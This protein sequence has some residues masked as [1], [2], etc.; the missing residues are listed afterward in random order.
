MPSEQESWKPVDAS[1]PELEKK[2]EALSTK[3]PQEDRVPTLSTKPKEEEPER[4]P[5]VSTSSAFEADFSEPGEVIIKQPLLGENVTEAEAS[6]SEFSTPLAKSPLAS[7]APSTPK[8]PPPG[9]EGELAKLRP[10]L[11]G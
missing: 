4:A 2:M 8:A 9:A 7:L 3:P 1:E 11:C 10:F 5:V 6:L